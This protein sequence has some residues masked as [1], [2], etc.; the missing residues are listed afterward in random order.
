MRQEVFE[1][2]RD[3]RWKRVE[4]L[5]GGLERGLCAEAHEFPSL[6]RALCQDLALARERGFSASLV[7]R[8]NGLALRGHE[9]LYG[10]QKDRIRPLLAAFWASVPRSVRAHRAALAFA[11]AIF[12]AITAASAWHG[13]HD[14][15][16]VYSV[17]ESERVAQF[18]AMYSDD[19]ELAESLR[20]A[21][22][23]AFMF[24]FYIYHNISIDF[25][26][27]ALGLLLGIGSMFVLTV[28]AVSMGT[29]AGHLFQKGSGDRLASFVVGHGAF[30]LPALFISAAA[31]FVL[32]MA[33]V[34]PG[35][36]SRLAALRHAAQSAQPLV[37]MAAIMGVV[38]AAL[39]A[40]W[41]PL[42][43]ASSI[44]YAVGALLWA[45]V[46]SGFAALGRTRAD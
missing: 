6:Y 15:G 19:P 1:R 36:R 14:E 11:T 10:A 8:L 16:F 44:K 5:L 4:S 7:E 21:D 3:E 13:Y 37:G 2:S 34:A 42:E 24:G 29:L 39:E 38:A 40:F 35:R 41:S 26:T 31:G 46:L 20:Q 33:W 25:S 27:F 32:G 23:R 9:Q 43:L 17:F 18:E 12:V 30:E 22:E 28:N 45:L